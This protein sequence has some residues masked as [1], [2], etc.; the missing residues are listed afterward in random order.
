M[1]VATKSSYRETAPGATTDGVTDC[2]FK[3]HF[4]EPMYCIFSVLLRERLGMLVNAN[5]ARHCLQISTYH[6]F[7]TMGLRHLTGLTADAK[8][9]NCKRHKT[10]EK[11]RILGVL[12]DRSESQH[13]RRRDY[14]GIYITFV[15][16]PNY[17]YE[18]V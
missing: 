1:C 8:H 7:R 4:T 6:S 18:L 14:P 10:L 17:E 16:E 11:I 2:F 12:G 13:K 9:R 15:L 5:K 3:R